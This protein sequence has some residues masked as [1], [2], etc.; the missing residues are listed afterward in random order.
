VLRH[1]EVAGRPHV[2]RGRLDEPLTPAGLARMATVAERLGVPP[3][4]RVASSPLVRCAAFARGYCADRGLPLEVLPAFAELDFGAWEG[5]TPDETVAGDPE[6]YRRF[7]AAAG[8]AAPPHGESVAALRRR[9][10]QGWAA[11][12]AG[13]DGGHRLLVTHAGVMRALLMELFGLPASHVYR[14]AL[15][16]AAHFTVSVLPGAAPVLLDLNRCAD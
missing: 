7:L 10:A 16:E 11:W 6:A 12:L 8:E 15:P 9:V 13:A 3:F 1:G 2:M 4:D 5:L 14:V